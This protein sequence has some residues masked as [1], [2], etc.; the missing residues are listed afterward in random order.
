MCYGHNL[1]A[2][3]H[4]NVEVT[5]LKLH[6]VSEQQLTKSWQQNRIMC[7]KICKAVAPSTKEEFCLVCLV[8]RCHGHNLEA[9]NHQNFEATQLKKQLHNNLSNNNP[10]S[11]NKTTHCTHVCSMLWVTQAS[12][13]FIAAR[14]C[15]VRLHMMNTE[16]NIMI[17]GCRS[18]KYD[19]CCWAVERHFCGGAV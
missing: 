18:T 12:S 11:D 1:E 7:T 5:R 8:Q 14:R 10:K 2:W 15:L 3:N 9:W 4:P 17:I 19:C 13:L 16:I 6:K